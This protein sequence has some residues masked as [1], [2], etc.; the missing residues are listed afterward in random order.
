MM[1]P[2]GREDTLTALLVLLFPASAYSGCKR[3]E[4]IFQ[5]VSL[6]SICYNSHM[7]S[8]QGRFLAD[9]LYEALLPLGCIDADR[10]AERKQ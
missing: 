5:V 1:K 10:A 8:R 9:I 6:K 7:K 4:F 2:T 3:S